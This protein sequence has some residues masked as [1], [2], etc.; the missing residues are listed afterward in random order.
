EIG[1]VIAHV[2]RVD[3][4]VRGAGVRVRG[5][6]GLDVRARCVRLGIDT[7]AHVFPLSRVRRMR[8]LLVPTQIVPA[9]TLDGAMVSMMPP[10]GGPPRPP[11]AGGCGAAGSRPCG[12]P[13]SGLSFVQCAPPSV[14]AMRYWKPANS[15]RWFHGAHTSGCVDP[16]RSSSFG[17]CA[18]LTLIHCSLGYVTFTMPLPLAYTVS[19]CSGSGTIVPHSHVGTGLQSS[20][21]ISPKLPRLRVRTAPASCCVA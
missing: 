21:V 4:H 17:S 10:V 19:G 12:T 15:S 3:R 13:K 5:V 14:V 11:R 7:S 2:V 6:D 16:M 20:G 9:A 18:G 1:R 8:P